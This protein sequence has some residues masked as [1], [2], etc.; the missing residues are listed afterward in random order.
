MGTYYTP[1]APTITEGYFLQPETKV[2]I[3][4]AYLWGSLDITSFTYANYVAPIGLETGHAIDLGELES[5]SFSHVPTF[6]PVESANVRTSNIYIVEGEET[7]CTVGVR[8]FKPQTILMAL[9]SGTMHSPVADERLITFGDKCDLLSRP[10]VLEFNDVSCQVPAAEDIT[11]GFSGGVITLY[12]AFASSGFVLDDMNAGA[13][14]VM[15]LEFTVRPVTSLAR[16]NRLGNFYM[17]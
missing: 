1:T 16:G 17:W 9:A 12:D 14:N 6:T 10:L 7:M 2:S 3:G 13:L 15:N 11:A 8:E 5:L 4:D